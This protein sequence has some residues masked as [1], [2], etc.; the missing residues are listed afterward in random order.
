MIMFY[1]F[2][3]EVLIKRKEVE[4][5]LVFIVKPETV[6]CLRTKCSLMMKDKILQSYVSKTVNDRT[7][8]YAYLGKELREILQY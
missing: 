7:S 6:I 4:L 3:H 5:L 1:V 2:V 8:F